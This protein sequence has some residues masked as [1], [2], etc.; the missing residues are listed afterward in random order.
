MYSQFWLKLCPNLVHQF[1]KKLWNFEAKDK[2]K[3]KFEKSVQIF[4]NFNIFVLKQR[5]FVLRSHS[6]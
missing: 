2:E 3:Y 6:S 5:I 1:L 4:A